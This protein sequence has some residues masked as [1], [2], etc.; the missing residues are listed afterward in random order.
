MWY[1]FQIRDGGLSTSPL[2]RR[3]CGTIVPQPITSTGSS[4]WLKFVSDGSVQNHGFRATYETTNGG[5]GGTDTA[6]NSQEFNIGK[7]K[8]MLNR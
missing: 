8:K 7:T 2:I 3:L 5:T 6:G 4:L 1:D